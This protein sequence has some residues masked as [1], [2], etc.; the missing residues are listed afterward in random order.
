MKALANVTAPA[1]YATARLGFAGVTGGLGW[2]GDRLGPGWRDALQG[3]AGVVGIVAAAPRGGARALRQEAVAARVRA[4]V[5]ESRAARGASGFREWETGSGGRTRQSGGRI[6][7]PTKVDSWDRAEREYTVFRERS[8]D[9]PAI[10]RNTGW[11][12]QRIS[13]IKDHVF[14]DEHRLDD[15][16][17]RFNADPEMHNA[18][19]RMIDGEHTPSDVKLLE[20]EY[21]ESRFERIFRTDYRTAH[22]ATIRSGRTWP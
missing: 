20:H 6:I 22:N 15:G 12:E 2:L 4:N 9:V 14:Y 11:S 7:D 19:Q 18:W 17:R 21:F 10:A 5:A 1:A 3:G 13:R 16:V 8:D